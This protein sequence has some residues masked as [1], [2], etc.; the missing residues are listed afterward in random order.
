MFTLSIILLS[1]LYTM[2]HLSRARRQNFLQLDAALI[3]PALSTI[4]PKSSSSLIPSMQP[5]KYSITVRILIKSIQ[6]P[7]SVNYVPSSHLMNPTL[8]NFGNA[9]ANSDGDFTPMSIKTP[10]HSQFRPP[11][12]Q[13]YP[14]IFAGKLIVTIPSI[15]GK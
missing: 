3:K 12:R 1:K 11:T 2:L 9:P 7:F 15:F 10:D 6:P 4:C 8:S 5:R 13:K 14:G